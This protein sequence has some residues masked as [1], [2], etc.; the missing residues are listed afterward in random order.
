[1]YGQFL[2]WPGDGLLLGQALPHPLEGHVHWLG[3]QEARCMTRILALG[4]VMGFSSR[5]VDGIAPQWLAGLAG[6][7]I[8]GL[9]ANSQYPRLYRLVG[10]GE[11]KERMSW[12]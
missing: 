1:M 7:H 5:V 12:E 6:I 9:S 2:G 4:I 3:G 8:F 11:V 10:S